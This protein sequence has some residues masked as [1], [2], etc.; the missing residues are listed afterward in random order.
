M[1]IKT[2]SYASAS[3]KSNHDYTMAPSHGSA[4]SPSKLFESAKA[5]VDAYGSPSKSLFDQ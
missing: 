1:D 5:K 3:S 2:P 4:P